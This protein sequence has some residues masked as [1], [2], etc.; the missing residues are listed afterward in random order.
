MAWRSPLKKGI[1][2]LR[3]PL[4]V[5]KVRKKGPS[6]PSSRASASPFE[7]KKEREREEKKRKRK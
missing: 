5:K 3:R 7:E 2:L 1:P 6:S 4:S